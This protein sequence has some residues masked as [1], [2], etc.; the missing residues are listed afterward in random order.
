[1]KFVPGCN[2]CTCT[3]DANHVC[4]CS[5]LTPYPKTATLGDDTGTVTLTYQN[6]GGGFRWRGT[7]TLH[8]VDTYTGSGLSCTLSPPPFTDLPYTYDLTFNCLTSKWT[9]TVTFGGVV[10]NSGGPNFSRYA[11]PGG[12]LPF[13]ISATIDIDCSNTSM[14]V[15]NLP[16]TTTD[17]TL[18]TPGGGGSMTVA[19]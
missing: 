19:F 3:A 4:I 2:C 15:F 1:M 6:P 8:G 16:A 5:C 17:G 12:G 18:A 9:L 14:L 10:C 11:T 13:T 7:S